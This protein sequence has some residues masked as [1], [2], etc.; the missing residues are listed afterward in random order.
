MTPSHGVA[1]VSASEVIAELSGALH[2]ATVEWNTLEL[3]LDA[4]RAR[5]AEAESILRA[6]MSWTDETVRNTDPDD[7]ELNSVYVRTRAWL[8]KGVA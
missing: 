1:V 7:P 2:V 3:E 8:A 4:A 6:W 5:L